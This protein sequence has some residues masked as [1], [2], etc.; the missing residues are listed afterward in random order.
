[1]DILYGI[2]TIGLLFIVGFVFL[3]VFFVIGCL[4][5]LGIFICTVITCAIGPI[6]LAFSTGNILCLCFYFITIPVLFFIVEGM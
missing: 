2:L 5:L 6:F 3:C 4:A 1:M